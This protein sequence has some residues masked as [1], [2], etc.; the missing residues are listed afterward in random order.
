MPQIT[1]TE[2]AAHLQE[3]GRLCHQEPVIVM[4]EGRPA[5]QLVP[6]DDDDNFMNDLIQN[7]AEFRE[8]MQQRRSGKFMSAEEALR[9]LE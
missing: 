5:F 8:L 7:N 6:V 4:S 1:L 3:Y 2:A 9:R